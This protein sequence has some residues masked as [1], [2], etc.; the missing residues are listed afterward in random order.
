MFSRRMILVRSKWDKPW[1]Q[2]VYALDASMAGWGM[3]Q[4]TWET[5][6]VSKVARL[7]ERMR[8][9][10]GGEK[11]REHALGA[12]GYMLNDFGKI[13]KGYDGE[14]LQIERDVNISLDAL[15]WHTEPDF[16]E[17]PI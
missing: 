7:N 9:G 10:F 3:T 12:G 6:G 2:E 4:A 16:P 8:F 14:P 15:R 1:C 11:A 5:A 17:V 13:L